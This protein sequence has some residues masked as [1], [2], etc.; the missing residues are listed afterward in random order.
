[1]ATS[2]GGYFLSI[3]GDGLAFG[4]SSMAITTTSTQADIVTRSIG[5]IQ[6]DACKDGQI[7][8]QTDLRMFSHLFSSTR[9]RRSLI[10]TIALFSISCAS[11]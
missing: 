11:V 6:S 1:M 7:N 9:V 10:I 4:R 2:P 8:S 5:I 3:G